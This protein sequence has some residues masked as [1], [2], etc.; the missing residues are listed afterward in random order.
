[1]PYPIAIVLRGCESIWEGSRGRGL[2]GEAQVRGEVT[3][4]RRHR[5]TGSLPSLQAARTRGHARAGPGCDI[6]VHQ[7]SLGSRIVG[8]R[9]LLWGCPR[10]R[11][12]LNCSPRSSRRAWGRHSKV[13]PGLNAF[14]VKGYARTLGRET[15]RSA[16][17]R[18]LGWTWNLTPVTASRM[19][20][21][22]GLKSPP[23]EWRRTVGRNY[24]GYG[25]RLGGSRRYPGHRD[26][27]PS[28]RTGDWTP[29]VLLGPDR[30]LG[31]P[32]LGE[33]SS[34]GGSS[35]HLDVPGGQASH[36][37]SSS[38]SR[39]VSWNTVRSELTHGHMTKA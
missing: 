8:V 7:Q 35:R 34:D 29:Y 26:S 1:L 39:D 20:F 23:H 28:S 5:P 27:V 32:L 11:S 37:A 19:K 15:G 38:C 12:H 24:E 3:P 21:S 25:Y 36:P 9:S 18:S 14:C 33:P 16:K 22:Q 30:L 17:L 13:L 10:G 6:K 2:G 31:P 4:R